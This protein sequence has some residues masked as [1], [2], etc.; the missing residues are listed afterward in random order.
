MAD[1]S[2]RI[3]TTGSSSKNRV[4]KPKTVSGEVQTLKDQNLPVQS[5]NQSPMDLLIASKAR[6]EA[7][8]A[9]TAE[10]ENAIAKKQL[11]VKA[12]ADKIVFE[13]G[14]FLLDS[15]LECCE[16]LGPDL[17][18]ETD[19]IKISKILKQRY[20]EILKNFVNEYETNI[21]KI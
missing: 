9:E 11:I 5:N 13:A 7:A 4:A 17:S 16:K 21:E 10:M 14:K 3:R 18:K 6:K 19:P 15:I 20:T 8:L 1:L 12:N 2:K